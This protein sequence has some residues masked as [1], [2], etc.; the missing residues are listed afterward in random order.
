M[1][2][3]VDDLN[4]EG[5]D[6]YTGY[7]QVNASKLLENMTLSIPKNPDVEPRFVNT[8]STEVTGVLNFPNPISQDGPNFSFY[9]P[10]GSRYYQ[11][12]VFDSN[13]AVL[14]EL[15][16]RS[17]QGQNNIYWPGTSMRDGTR[18]LR[19]SYFWVLSFSGE[20]QI[21]KNILVVK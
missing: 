2:R 8:Q 10:Q 4:M 20:G 12:Q 18:L 21:H 11:I 19:G 16:G 9:D 14:Q 5:K 6:R 3:S 15:S 1:Q 7:G 13:G 17:S